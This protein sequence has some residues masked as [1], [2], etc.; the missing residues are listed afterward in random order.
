[1]GSSFARRT[2]LARCAVD[3]PPLDGLFPC[4]CHANVRRGELQGPMKRR[5][6]ANARAS[7]RTRR[8]KSKEG[9]EEPTTTTDQQKQ[10]SKPANQPTSQASLVLLLLLTEEFSLFLVASV[11]PFSIPSPFRSS[12]YLYTRLFSSLR[13]QRAPS[14]TLRLGACLSRAFL[15]SRS[16]SRA[17][18]ERGERKREREREAGGR[19]VCSMPGSLLSHGLMPASTILVPPNDR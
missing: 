11:S 17:S 5:A 15:T 8:V 1:M 19:R 16:L 3:S 7:E 6:R 12:P 13:P 2:A 18:N 10:P 9:E 4:L 14:R